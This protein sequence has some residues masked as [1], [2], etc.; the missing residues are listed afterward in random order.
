M[1]P[2]KATLF[3][4]LVVNT[5]FF[6]F[7][8]TASKAVDACAWLTLLLLFEAET[9]FGAR[10]AADGRRVALRMARLAAGAG[11]IAA[12]IGYV[13]EENPLDA[14]NSVLWILV[15][16]LLELELRRPALAARYR[17][18]LGAVGLAVYG[19]LA[20][21]VV[22]WATAGMWLDAYDAVLWLAAFA[23]IELKLLASSRSSASAPS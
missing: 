8:G 22:L 7:F 4:L 3:I 18:T 17:R 15:V 14:A 1:S 6:V 10:F 5:A 9:S 23:A 21:L 19:S 11:V 16:M 20:L 12:T 13:F 2:T